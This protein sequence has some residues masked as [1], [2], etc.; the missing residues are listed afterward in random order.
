MNTANELSDASSIPRGVFDEAPDQT[1]VLL[2]DFKTNGRETFP[3]VLEQLQALREKDYLT[4]HDGTTLHSRPVT[5]VG[6]GNTPFDMIT[7]MPSRRDIFFDAPLDEMWE[8]PE[9]SIASFPNTEIQLTTPPTPTTPASPSTAP[10]AS[11]GAVVSP[12]NKPTS[13]EVKSA[14]RTA[15]G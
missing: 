1:L 15:E 8:A 14:A 6:T 11:S 2:V 10:S 4:Y 7:G 3:V 9:T 12:P 13:C 5:V